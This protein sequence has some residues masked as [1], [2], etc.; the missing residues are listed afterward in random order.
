MHFEVEAIIRDVGII[1]VAVMVFA[2]SGLLIGIMLPGDS[3]LF[4]AGF[5]AS[6][7]IIDINLLVVSVII[8]AI[9]GD[10]V[11]Y[12]FGHRAGKRLFKRKDSRFFK[13]EYLERAKKF[14]EV[15]GKKTIVLARFTPIVR[16]FAPIVAGATNMEHKVFFR[17]NIVGGVIW[18]GGVT[19][20]GYWLGAK[21]PN[22]EKYLLPAVAIV[23]AVSIAVPG[24]IHYMLERNHHSND[25][26]LEEKEPIEK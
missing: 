17:Y 7:N 5:L 21:I 15:H 1:G 18:G 9:A 26:E 20:L 25:K 14:Y 8:A 12:S 22:I 4:T 6:Q 2:E 16:T 3:L 24:I 11:G 13:Q 10:N 23:I 19:Y